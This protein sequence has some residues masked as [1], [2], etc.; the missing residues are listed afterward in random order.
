MTASQPAAPDRSGAHEACAQD[1]ERTGA[2]SPENRDTTPYVRKSWVLVVAYYAATSLALGFVIG[3]V[4]FL[5]LVLNHP[6]DGRHARAPVLGMPMFALAAMGVISAAT[7]LIQLVTGPY[8]FT[9]DVV[10]RRCHTRLRVNRI[11][12]FTG[13]YSRPPRC[14]C[15]GPIEPAFLWKPDVPRLDSMSG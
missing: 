15:G 2:G 7:F 4:L 12:F 6:P 5:F 9:K 3:A 11:A 13:R 1:G 10:C 8:V 14:E